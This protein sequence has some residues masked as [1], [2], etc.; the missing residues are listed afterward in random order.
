MLY[1]QVIEDTHLI[2]MINQRGYVSITYNFLSNTHYTYQ[3]RSSNVESQRV[4]VTLR[5]GRLGLKYRNQ[6]G[7]N[8][9]IPADFKT[10]QHL[11]YI[12]VLA[13]SVLVDSGLMYWELDKLNNIAL[14]YIRYLLCICRCSMITIVTA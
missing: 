1:T 2:S 9:N 8:F 3:T 10:P 7:S 11:T 12:S 14:C 4:Y 13:I 6:C 5:E